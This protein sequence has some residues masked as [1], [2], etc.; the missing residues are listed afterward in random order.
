MSIKK[1]LTSPL[2]V[3]GMLVA[4]IILTACGGGRRQVDLEHKIDSIKKLEQLEQ[5]KLQG[6]Q[7]EDA[8]PFQLFFDSL[9]IQ[10]LPLRST[11]D[12][13]HYLPN[14]Q[15]VPMELA[16]LMGF[17]GRVNPRAITLPESLGARLMLLAADA[18]DGENSLWLY[19]INDDYLPADKL[20]LFEPRK[21]SAKELTSPL[22][23]GFSITS[24][25]QVY[26]YLVT[27][28]Q[29]VKGT[30]QYTIDASRHFAEVVAN[31]KTNR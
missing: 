15:P 25:Y 16:D 12:Y 27:D 21:Q 4:G 13:V 14:F 2:S 24:D 31:E 20:L 22:Q 30:R 18:A 9:A 6:I 29:Q 11:D 28:D 17:E 7:L 19:S 3:V 23:M 5:L 26:V 10:P 8:N 1:N